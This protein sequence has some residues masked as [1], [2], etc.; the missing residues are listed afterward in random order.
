MPPNHPQP[1]FRKSLIG[2]QKDACKTVI[3]KVGPKTVFSESEDVAST[4]IVKPVSSAIKT[5]QQLKLKET[6]DQGAKKKEFDREKQL[7]N[8]WF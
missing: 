8:P 4:V 2:A 1:Q 6:L 5:T 7:I 3:S